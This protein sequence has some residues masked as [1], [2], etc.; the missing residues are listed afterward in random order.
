MADNMQEYGF[1]WSTRFNGGPMPTPIRIPV[2][3]GQNFVVAAA[4]YSLGAGDVVLMEATGM[5]D[6]SLA[7]EAIY[8]IVVG[9]E[10]YWDGSVMRPSN[11]LP[12]GVAYGTNLSR[13]SALL[14]VPAHLGFWEADADDAVTATTQAAYQALIGTNC[15]HAHTPNATTLRVH[16]RIDIS[17]TKTATAQWRLVNIAGDVSNK[18]FSGNYV[19]LIVAANETQWGPAFTA[20][21]I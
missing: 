12:S 10:P 6:I 5:L 16:P 20:T 8:G 9:V 2:A 15:D 14:V 4:N 1:R 3:T 21:G 7:G 19:K 18:D 11:L 13:Q 17:D